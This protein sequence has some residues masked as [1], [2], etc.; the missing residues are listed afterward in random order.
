MVDASPRTSGSSRRV[1][2]SG[3]DA[4]DIRIVEELQRDARLP[5]AA[6]ATRVGVSRAATYK[7]LARLEATGA[8]TGYTVRSDPAALGLPLAAIVM[9]R[10]DQRSWRDVRDAV[11][12]LDALEYLAYCTGEFDFLALVRARDMTDLRDAVLQPLNAI[13]GLLTTRTTLVLDEM[14]SQARLPGGGG[15]GRP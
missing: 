12:H 7:R 15:G 14:T 13:P 1:L 4:L 9:I 3:L 11:L 8:V 6:L 10:T 2:P 5:V